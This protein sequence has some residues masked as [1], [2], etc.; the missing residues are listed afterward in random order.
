MSPSFIDDDINP[1]KHTIFHTFQL[2]TFGRTEICFIK[3]CRLVYI[4][5][6]PCYSD[7]Y[8]KF[9]KSV[10]RIIIHERPAWIFWTASVVKSSFS[11]K[12]STDRI[13]IPVSQEEVKEIKAIVEVA[14]KE[15]KNLQLFVYCNLLQIYY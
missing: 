8:S 11:N 15:R 3:I 13:D 10:M 6:A 12:K 9:I 5:L 7:K 2:H 4:Q 14:S 1:F